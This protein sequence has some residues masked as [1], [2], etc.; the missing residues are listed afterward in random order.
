MPEALVPC[1]AGADDPELS[2]PAP[3]DGDDEP[4]RGGEIGDPTVG[5]WTGGID[6]VLTDGTVMLGVVT[7]GVV[8]RGV[9]TGPVVTDGTVT[10]GTVTGGTVTVGTEVVG[11]VTVGIETVGIETVGIETVGTVTVGTVTAGDAADA[12][13]LA[14]ASSP[15]DTASTASRRRVIGRPATR[16]RTTYE[17]TRASKLRTDRAPVLF[18][19]PGKPAALSL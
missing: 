3:G 17:R 6:G 10:D 14:D 8:T 9:V 18:Y 1:T 11:T 4:R 19:S 16:L 5:V 12:A 15:P 2:P 7:R 13:A